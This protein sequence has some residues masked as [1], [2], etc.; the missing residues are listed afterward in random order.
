MMNRSEGRPGIKNHFTVN[1]IT[2]GILIAIAI[3]LIIAPTSGS[4]HEAD[5]LSSLPT[6]DE[7]RAPASPAF[8]LLG[9]S[10]SS[11]ER[12]NTPRALAISILSSTNRSNGNFPQDFAIDV[13]PYWLVSHPTLTFDKYYKPDHVG[14]TILRTL[15]FSLATTKMPDTGDKDGTSLGFGLQFLLVHGDAAPNLRDR[16]QKLKEKQLG[17]LVECVPMIGEVKV[18]TNSPK[19][20]KLLAEAEKAGGAIRKLD[21]QRVGWIVAFASAMVADFP[22]NDVSEGNVTRVGIWLTPSYRSGNIDS[23]LHQLTFVGIGRY[24]WDDVADNSKNLFDIGARIIWT[25][26]HLPLS[27]SAEYV[28]RF[29]EGDTD[30]ERIAFV[31]EYRVQDDISLF[32][33]YG[34]NFDTSFEGNDDLIAIAGVKFGFGKGPVVTP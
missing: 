32:A 12:P 16:V 29:V 26:K 28:Q 22:R 23:L 21:K 13:A 7:L 9:I 1:N 15:Y 14:Q 27:L 5:E 31:F 33:S 19:C 3:L 10:P 6:M 8:D 4:C 30:T 17:I 25:S 20:K 18:D 24:I 11:V 2:I 34:T